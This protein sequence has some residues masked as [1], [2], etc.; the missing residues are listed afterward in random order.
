MQQR[1]MV[2]A[3][4]AGSYGAG[5]EAGVAECIARLRQD[6]NT[7]SE[8][9]A[10]VPAGPPRSSTRPQVTNPRSGSEP[11]W[12]LILSLGLGGAFVGGFGAWRYKVN[13]T[14]PSCKIRMAMLLEDEDDAKLD[15][16]QQAEEALGSVDYQ[17]HYCTQCDFAKLIVKKAWFSG[18]SRCDACSYRTS[19]TSSRTLE[20]ATYESSGLEEITTQCSHCSHT[21]SHTRVIPRKVR[22]ESSSSSSGSSGF[23]GGG[24]FSGGGGGGS[25]GG[26][27]SGGGGAGSSW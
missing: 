11:P 18:Y 5:L 8:G 7:I 27:S 2:P 4:K 25:F 23:G 13:R 22:V 14:C 19:R 16:G 20:Y 6:P 21:S 26:G 10:P 15:A 9:A 24:G 17:F 3:F 12:M 1:V